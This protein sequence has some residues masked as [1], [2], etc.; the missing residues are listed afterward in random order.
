MSIFGGDIAIE[1]RNH[2]MKLMREDGRKP[3]PVN[4]QWSGDHNIQT[5]VNNQWPGNQSTSMYLSGDKYGD[6]RRHNVSNV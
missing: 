1:D 4:H 3:V 2:I 6:Y 5:P